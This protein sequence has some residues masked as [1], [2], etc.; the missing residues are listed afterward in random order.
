MKSIF[1]ENKTVEEKIVSTK[2]L[3]RLM[4][5]F[6]FIIIG[7]VL[8]ELITMA[9]GHREEFTNL[10]QIC[11]TLGCVTCALSINLKRQKEFEAE[12]ENNQK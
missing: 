11:A 5:I 2:R 8:Y 12:L 4:L 3:I 7:V 6:I 1:C 10:G 9:T